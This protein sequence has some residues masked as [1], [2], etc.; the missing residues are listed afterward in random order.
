MGRP[1][2]NV[3]QSDKPPAENSSAVDT[4]VDKIDVQEALKLRLINKLTYQQIADIYG[5]TRQAVQQRLNTLLGY[6]S[7]PEEIQSYKDTRPDILTAVE[8]NLL[9]HILSPDKLE[10]ATINNLA[11][12]FQQVF[13]AR[14]LEEGKTTANLHGIYGLVLQLDR[15]ERKD[16]KQDN[17]PIIEAEYVDAPHK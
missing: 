2:K 13:N 12:A 8:S 9:Q 17:T 10:K 7:G 15:D 5:C 14:R 16:T 4:T 6:F 11:Y 3:Q 1:R